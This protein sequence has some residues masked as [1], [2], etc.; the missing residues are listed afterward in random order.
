MT[1]ARLKLSKINLNADN[2]E[3]HQC[4]VLEQLPLNATKYIV[5]K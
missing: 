2:P 4:T 3:N 1:D 5:V